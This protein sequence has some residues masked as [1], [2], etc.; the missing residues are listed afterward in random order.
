MLWLS[1]DCRVR[2]LGADATGAIVTLTGWAMARILGAIVGLGALVAASIGLAA[3]HPHGPTIGPAKAAVVAPDAIELD[4]AKVRLW[5][6]SLALS[7]R[8]CPDYGS[9]ATCAAGA[10]WELEHIIQDHE[11]T[12]RLVGGADERPRA[13]VC[14]VRYDACYGVSCKPYWRDLSEELI[15][16]G[17]VIQNRDESAG[18]YD[19][20]EDAARRG[21]TGLWRQIPPSRE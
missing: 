15:E 16:A 21:A 20:K 5:G 11:V 6:V 19:A 1:L 14:E 18:R 7:E 10:V 4:G 8:P 3:P 9:A 12:C 17:V 2:R 13:G